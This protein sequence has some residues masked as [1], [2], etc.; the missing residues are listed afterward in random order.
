[1][2][3]LIHDCPARPMLPSNQNYPPQPAKTLRHH[4]ALVPCLP[5]ARYLAIE[6]SIHIARMH[7]RQDGHRG[8]NIRNGSCAHIPNDSTLTSVLSSVRRQCSSTFLRKWQKSISK[9]SCSKRDWRGI[10]HSCTCD[11]RPRSKWWLFLFYRYL[12]ITHIGTPTS[13]IMCESPSS[14]VAAST[15]RPRLSP[16]SQN[17]TFSIFWGT[18]I[19][20]RKK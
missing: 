10:S 9:S 15:T 2:P 20:S 12:C 18:S 7:H 17:R 16:F 4:R 1:M 14:M 11:I 8:H 13:P 19:P 5:I 3:H 6:V